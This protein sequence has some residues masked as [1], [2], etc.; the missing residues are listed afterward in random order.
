MRVLG[1]VLACVINIW[2]AHGAWATCTIDRVDLRGDWG[3]VRIRVNV[4]DTPAERAQG[5]MNVMEMPRFAGMLFVYQRPQ[6][7]NFWMENTFIPLDMLFADATGR[8]Q[9]IHENATP[10]DRTPIP[11]GDDIQ[12]V[13]EI[14]G[15]L[16]ADLGIGPGTQIRHPAISP[17]IA[18]WPCVAQ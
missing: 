7:V 16:S 12:Y 5:L 8:I 1:L 18:V 4:A 14:N 15:G 3:T 9:H 11:G 17:D 10:L 6:P 13:L 2:G